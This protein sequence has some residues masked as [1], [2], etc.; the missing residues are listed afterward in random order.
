M[1]F[2]AKDGSSRGRSHTTYKSNATHA[3]AVRLRNTFVRT[4]AAVLM[5]AMI[6]PLAAA[7]AAQAVAT[8]ATQEEVGPKHGNGPLRLLCFQIITA[9]NALV[10]TQVDLFLGTVTLTDN[11]IYLEGESI[12]SLRKPIKPAQFPPDPLAGPKKV[13]ENLVGFVDS[14]DPERPPVFQFELLTPR[15][16]DQK[17]TRLTIMVKSAQCIP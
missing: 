3:G 17:G 12:V 14:L 6:V 13:V 11:A 15:I 10:K 7:P 4:T 9:S 1:G 2:V 16:D 5:A 8:P